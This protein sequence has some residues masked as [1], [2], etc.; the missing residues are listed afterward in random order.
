MA[1]EDPIERAELKTR[2][3]KL[4]AQEKALTQQLDQIGFTIAKF[5]SSQQVFQIQLTGIQGAKRE[6]QDI[7]G[8]KDG[9]PEEVAQ[10]TKPRG[11]QK[12]SSQ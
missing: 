7:L 12:P 2:L 9:L 1:Q 6:L 8:I 11:E 4:I 10:T 5:T 3:V